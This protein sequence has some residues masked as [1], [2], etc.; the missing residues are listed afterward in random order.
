MII[1]QHYI[2]LFYVYLYISSR[3]RIKLV[4]ISTQHSARLCSV[5]ILFSAVIAAV[6]ANSFANK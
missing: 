4:K 1:I 6:N 3:E 5:Q 2:A